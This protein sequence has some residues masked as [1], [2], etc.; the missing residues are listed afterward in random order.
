VYYGNSAGEKLAL[1]TQ[2]TRDIIEVALRSLIAFG[3][4]VGAI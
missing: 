4:M 2:D 3:W 1:P